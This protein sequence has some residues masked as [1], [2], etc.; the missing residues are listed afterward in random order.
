MIPQVW[1]TCVSAP[2]ALALPH[3]TSPH[4]LFQLQPQT[5]LH[6]ASH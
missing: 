6:P 1:E 5:L 3:Y 4:P 2:E